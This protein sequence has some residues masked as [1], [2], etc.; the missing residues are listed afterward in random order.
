VKNFGLVVSSALLAV[1]MV[2]GADPTGEPAGPRTHT[3]RIEGMQYVPAEIHVRPGDTVVF[4]NADLVPHTVTERVLHQFDSGL[5]DKGASWKIT[6]PKEGT[7]EYRCLYHPPM[8]GTIK[9]ENEKTAAAR[10]GRGPIELCG[11][12]LK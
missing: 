3:V 9:V 5:I 12:P 11:A 1:V 10:G 6:C 2:C 8:L 7:F 4:L